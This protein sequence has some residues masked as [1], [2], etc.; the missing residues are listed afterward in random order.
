MTIFGIRR[1][2][3]HW[4][5][6]FLETIDQEKC[7]GCGRCYKSCGR[8]VLELVDKPFEGDDEYGDDMD[9]KV[10]SVAEKGLCI[11]CETCS[12]VCPKKCQT[13]VEL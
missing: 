1:D 4:T 9:N 10:M 7:I 13:Y 11:G 8:G 5:P 6:R 3:L 12:K 2:G